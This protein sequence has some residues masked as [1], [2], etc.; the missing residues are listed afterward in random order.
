MDL[1]TLLQSESVNLERVNTLLAERSLYEFVKQ[2]WPTVEPGVEFQDNWH[3]EVM[4]DHLQ[5]VTEG[6]I[7]RLAINIPPRHMKSTVVSVCWPVW[8]WINTPHRKFLCASYAGALSTR[9]SVKSRRLLQSKWFQS[10]W[11]DR[12]ALTGDQN[13]KQRYENDKTGYRIATSV[14]GGLTGEGGDII[15]IDDPHN[16]R[17]AESDTTRANVLEWWDQALPSRLNDPKTGAFVVIMQRVHEKDLIGHILAK[18]EHDEWDLLC[19][20]ARHEIKH[21]YKTR[22]SLRF[23]DPRTEEGELLWPNRFDEVSLARLERSLGTYGSAGQLQQ[24]PSPKGGGILRRAWWRLWDRMDP[25]TRTVALP[26]IE[27]VLQSWDTAYSE[28]DTA[29]YSARTTWGVFQ[30]GSR[31]NAILL[32]RWRDRVDYPSLKKEAMAAY[33]QEKPDAVIVEKKA[34][35]QSLIKELRQSS[36]PVISY[37]PDRDKV[38]RAHAAS[39]LFEAGCVWYVDK[40]WAHEVIDQCALFPAGDGADT[41]DTVTQAIL[42]LRSMW[43][44][45]DPTD[46]EVNEDNVA[47][48]KPRKAIY[49]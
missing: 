9:D 22:S 16:V 41:V 24:R 39:V 7:T 11:G 6:K 30:Y 40:R 26:E 31:W 27:Y 15:V 49:G 13:Q 46:D 19:F 20:P 48:F 37:T 25:V 1:A 5:A 44:L 14:D 34:S 10:R 29:A 28:R 35:G 2:A 36:I 38:A 8:S 12:F 4:C 23:T 45:D 33:K 47:E 43:F 42:R 17:E 32:S 3:I 21:P 18:D